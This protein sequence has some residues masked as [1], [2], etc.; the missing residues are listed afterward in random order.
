V[1]LADEG[2]LVPFY[3]NGKAVGTIWAIAHDTGRKFDAEDLRLLESMGRFASAAYQA[4][5]SVENLRLEIAA[6]EKAETEVRE[7]A[8]GLEAKIRRL[9]EANVVGIVMWNLEGAITGANEAFLRMLQY[10]LEDLACGRLR[11]PDLTPA[12][13][14]PDDERAVVDLKATG[15]FQ[16]F[17]K[18]YLRKDGSRV[19]VLLGGALFEAVRVDGGVILNASMTDYRVPRIE[20]VPPIEV[21]LLD[22]P[23][24]PSA[25]AGETPIVA[26]APAIANA[27][28]AAT[29]IRLRSLPLVPDG[30]VPEPASAG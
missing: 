28:V 7:L 17:E 8:R 5:Q 2:L 4:V 3:V 30:V 14:R 1:P 22:R 10:D 20:D 24:L 9:V 18:E 19:P 15:I 21:I 13:W 12:E 23:E 25:G 11:W 29:G 27:I 26:I 6:R 16:P